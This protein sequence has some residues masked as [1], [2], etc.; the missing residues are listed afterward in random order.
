MNSMEKAHKETVEQLQVSNC[1]SVVQK[2]FRWNYVFRPFTHSKESTQFLN[3][4]YRVIKCFTS[5]V[6][7]SSSAVN[8]LRVN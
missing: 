1:L 3:G 8:N 6:F 4:H 5:D 7:Y 2:Y